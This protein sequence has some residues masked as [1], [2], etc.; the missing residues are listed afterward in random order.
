MKRHE[1]ALLSPKQV[2]EEFERLGRS[3]SGWAR[4]NGFEPSLVF[5]VL[6]GRR[7]CKRG[8]SH[9]IAVLLRL[10]EGVIEKRT[11]H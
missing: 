11:H 1:S 4:E 3:I 9:Q 8:K 7:R 10:K 5:E 6:S 2:R